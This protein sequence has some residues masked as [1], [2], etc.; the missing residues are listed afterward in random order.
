M[1]EQ[2]GNDQ[3][4]DQAGERDEELQESSANPNDQGSDQSDQSSGD[5][6]GDSDSQ[7][8]EADAGT[9]SESESSD[10]EVGDESADR[11]PASDTDPEA[12][13][14]A[15]ALAAATAQASQPPVPVN[16]TGAALEVAALAAAVA[17]PVEPVVS[18]VPEQAPEAAPATRAPSVTASKPVPV[19][20]D[21]AAQQAEIKLQNIRDRLTGYAEAMAPNKVLTATVGK[22]QQKSLWEAIQQTL[23]LEGAEF[24]K[25]YGELLDFFAKHRTTLFNDRYIYRFFAEAPLSS[26]D[27]K[28][29]SRLLNL[30]VATSDKATRRLGLEQVDL[31]RTLTDIRDTAIQQRIAEFYQI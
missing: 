6:S 23:R 18:D 15:A 17:A 27:R 21:V 9:G 3:Q 8:G 14:L 19:K 30:L 5:E 12:E 25:A 16:D 11:H 26:A 20:V 10:D 2:N 31:N 22:D 24:I 1:S 7:E 4:L 28:N 29:F 13:Q